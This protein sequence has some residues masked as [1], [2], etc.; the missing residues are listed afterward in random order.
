MKK[1]ALKFPKVRTCTIGDMISYSSAMNGQSKQENI[2][3][4]V[5]FTLS[6]ITLLNKVP[7]LKWRDSKKIVRA[8][9]AIEKV[10]ISDTLELVSPKQSCQRFSR[11]AINEMKQVAEAMG[12]YVYRVDNFVCVTR[13]PMTLNPVEVRSLAE[14]PVNER[15]DSSPELP[16][17]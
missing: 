10:G 17:A 7:Q 11:G 15:G 12:L 5:L 9:E 3:K 1:H 14:M 2:K 4:A 8:I 6:N 13:T 16:L